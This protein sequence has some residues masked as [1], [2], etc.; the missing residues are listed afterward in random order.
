MTYE[1]K[2]KRLLAR[3]AAYR[4]AHKAEISVYYKAWYQNNKLELARRRREK[5]NIQQGLH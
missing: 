2:Y 1:Q 5:K 4:K 3:Q